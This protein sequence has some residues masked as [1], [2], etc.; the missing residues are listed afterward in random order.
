MKNR[1]SPRKRKLIREKVWKRVNI[2]NQGMKAVVRRGEETKWC[3]KLKNHH[4]WLKLKNKTQLRDVINFTQ[5]DL[6][7]II[8][9][10]GKEYLK[11]QENQEAHTKTWVGIVHYKINQ[12]REISTITRKNK[13][14]LQKFKS[15][16]NNVWLKEKT[17]IQKRFN[18]T[19]RQK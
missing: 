15:F 6:T 14:Q 2:L 16:S 19:N 1:M 18:K 11:I 7:W 3:K 13:S 17:T 4:Y 5:R 8:R 10:L 9:K 12:K